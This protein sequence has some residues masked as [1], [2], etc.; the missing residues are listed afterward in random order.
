MGILNHTVATSLAMYAAVITILLRPVQTHEMLHQ[1]VPS[2]LAITPQ[3][4]KA[5]QCTRISNIVK[6]Q[7]SYFLSVNISYKENVK[8]NYPVVTPLSH[9]SNSS[10]TYAEATS[11]SYPNTILPP[12]SYINK[13]FDNFKLLI[14]S[15]IAQLT[16]VISKLLN[17]N[18]CPRPQASLSLSFFTTQMVLKITQT[19]SSWYFRKSVSTLL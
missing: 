17:K 9:P 18:E 16:Q 2:A 1:I 15:L 5:A 3:I 11:G 6:K 14:N 12:I 7:K 10:Q 19:N 8:V 4:I 13:C